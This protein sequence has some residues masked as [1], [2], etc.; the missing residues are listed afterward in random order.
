MASEDKQISL[1]ERLKWNFQNSME[2]MLEGREEAST[3]DGS[4]SASMCL[5]PNTRINLWSLE[6]TKP[7]KM[8]PAL[9]PL[10]EGAPPVN[11]RPYR[12]PPTQKDAIK[13]MVKELLEAGV[14]KPSHSAFASP[15]VMFKKKD[16]TLRMCV[17]Y[18]QLNKNTIKD[19]FPILIIKKLI[20]ELH[21]AFV[22]S[23]LDKS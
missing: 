17:D 10:T 7:H 19:K 22:F 1:A 23:K 21:G 6:N 2:M 15:I 18:W 12:H 4:C 3:T 8:I 13:A 16:N 9:I 5:Y 11:I 20:D 14:F